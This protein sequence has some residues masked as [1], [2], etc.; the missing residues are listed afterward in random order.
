MARNKKDQTHALSRPKWGKSGSLSN[1]VAPTVKRLYTIFVL[2][3]L[4][5]FLATYH[6]KLIQDN[7][8]FENLD[9]GFKCCIPKLLRFKWV[10]IARSSTQVSSMLFKLIMR[11]SLK[12]EYVE[13]IE[14]RG[15]YNEIEKFYFN[16]IN[17]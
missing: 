15:I 12:D 17:Q 10:T 4:C 9:V 13:I 8:E 3:F 16:K 7:T 2:L 1:P 6:I 14:K 5:L 11:F